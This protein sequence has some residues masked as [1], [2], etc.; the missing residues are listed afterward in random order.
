MHQHLPKK[1]NRVEYA[2][3]ILCLAA[4]AAAAFRVHT[5]T[6]SQPASQLVTQSTIAAFIFP[7]FFLSL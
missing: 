4:A 2:G 6:V 3:H 7:S 5:L 1:K